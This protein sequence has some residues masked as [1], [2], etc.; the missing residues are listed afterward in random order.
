[1]KPLFTKQAIQILFVLMF[2]GFEGKSQTMPTI[3]Q[4]YDYN[5][6]DEFHYRNFNTTPNATRF[7]I[8]GKS[9]SVLNDTVFY[10]RLFDNY[11]TQVTGNPN[12]PINTFFDSYID[13]IFYT[14]LD[15]LINAQFQNWPIDSNGNWFN[16]TVYFSPEMCGRLI[17]EFN[18][19]TDCILDGTYYNQKYGQGIGPVLLYTQ[20]AT[21][22]YDEHNYLIYYK[23]DTTECG[24]PDTTVITNLESVKAKSNVLVYPNPASSYI[25]IDILRPNH[26]QNPIISVYSLSGQLIMQQSLSSIKTKIYIGNLSK[27]IYILKLISNEDTEE[28]KFLK[29]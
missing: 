20:S 13:T 19:C 8:L 6:N 23:K 16:D 1:M 10:T 22:Q 21:P 4:V 9:F 28:I 24:T 25:T 7:K 18:A 3:G 26:M 2:F 29:E 12:H 17:Y 11:Y 15:T 27:G 14:N 5:I